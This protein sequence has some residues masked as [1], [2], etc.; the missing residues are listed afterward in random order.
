MAR[1]ELGQVLSRF[2]YEAFAGHFDEWLT[3]PS[4][5]T[6]TQ[7]SHNR[8]QGVLNPNSDS[9]LSLFLKYQKRRLSGHL[10]TGDYQEA[11]DLVER[12]YAKLQE[13]PSQGDEIIAGLVRYKASRGLVLETVATKTMDSNNPLRPT[14]FMYAARQYMDADFTAGTVTPYGLRTAACL[15]GAG[16]PVMAALAV[17][18]FFGPGYYTAMTPDEI[19][20]LA[21][22]ARTVTPV[23]R[24]P[25]G[26]KIQIYGGIPKSEAPKGPWVLVGK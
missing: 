6:L 11:L 20:A 22:K 10:K 19:V 9:Q 18:N 4:S 23:G 25:Y 2:D 8:V 12:G 24:V 1:T 21:S 15:D 3:L 14:L 5:T 16:E 13:K 26:G 7:E 17:A